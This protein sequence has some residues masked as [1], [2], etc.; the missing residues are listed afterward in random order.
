MIVNQ[1]KK[2]GEVAHNFK[3]RY[4]DSKELQKPTT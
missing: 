1:P 3:N 4:I 2:H